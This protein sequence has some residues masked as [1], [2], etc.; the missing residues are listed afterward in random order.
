MDLDDDELKATRNKFY[1]EN[2]TEFLNEIPNICE[3]YNKSN[4]YVL[5]LDYYDIGILFKYIEYQR[6]QIEELKDDIN[7]MWSHIPRLD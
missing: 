4:K 3:K 5:Y 2:T 6:Q 1:S 7:E